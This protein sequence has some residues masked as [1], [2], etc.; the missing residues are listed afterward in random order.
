MIEK[1]AESTGNVLGFMFTG[2]ITDEEYMGYFIP[3]LRQA[4]ETYGT[5]RVLIDVTDIQSEDFGAM[6]DDI[7]ARDR[8]LYVE[9]EAIVGDEDWEKRLA[10][11]DHLFLF[12][13]TDVRFFRAANRPAAWR[14]IREGMLVGRGT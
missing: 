10:N 5:I 14:W 6:N 4:I 11:V 2:E 13:N 8:V 9:R 3:A 7:R 1:M 12:S